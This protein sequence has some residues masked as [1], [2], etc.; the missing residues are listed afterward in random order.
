MAGLAV[1][2]FGSLEFTDGFRKSP[3]RFLSEGIQQ[4]LDDDEVFRLAVFHEP[5]CHVGET[6]ME[7]E[8]YVGGQCPRSSGPDD[9]G[10]FQAQGIVQ[11][12]EAH[13]NGG[14]DLF[15]VVDFR[16]RQRRIGP[17]G[18]LDGFAALVHRSVFH[19]FGE[20]AQDVGLIRRL[21]GQVGIL[22][23]AEHAQ[24]AEGSALNVNE[25]FGEFR[26]ASADFRRIQVTGLL[27]HLEFDGE[28]VA[29]PARNIGGGITG[30]GF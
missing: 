18:P 20:H 19:Q 3:A 28:A 6:R 1:F 25:A 22:P 16:F 11:K 26:T 24:A 5:A 17:I 23:V 2:Q 14:T 8:T 15:L 13:E 21:H 29:V 12:R 27:N 10:C 4:I 9:H 30:H 7:C